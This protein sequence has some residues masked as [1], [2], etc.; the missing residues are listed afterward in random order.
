MNES[1]CPSTDLISSMASNNV[2]PV[3][4]SNPLDWDRQDVVK[5]PVPTNNVIVYD[6]NGVVVQSEV[7]RE[8]GKYVL[9][10]LAQLSP[11]GF[12]TYFIGKT[13]DS[14]N[15]IKALLT[16]DQIEN[17]FF[18]LYF[19]YNQL[20]AIFDK[21]TNTNSSLTQ[22]FLFYDPITSENGQQASGAYIFRPNGFANII[23]PTV[24][25]DF[26]AGKLVQ[27]AVQTVTPWV[28]QIIRLYQ[29]SPAIEFETQIG[30]IDISN[31]KGREIISRI[32]TDVANSNSFYTDAQGTEMTLRI[33]NHRDS[34]NVNLKEP[35]AGNYY[36]ITQAIAIN[37]SKIHYT[38][39]SDRTRGASSLNQGELE[40]MIHRR[41][42]SDDS[43]GVGEPLNEDNIIFTRDYLLRNA[44][45]KSARG[46]R[47]Q[48]QL[49]LNPIQF[50]FGKPTPLN[51]WKNQYTLTYSPLN[52]PLPPNVYIQTLRPVL[53]PMSDKRVLLRLRHIYAV[54]EDS[55]L[56]KPVTVNIANLFKN[57]SISLIKEMSL[58]GT[59]EI[60]QVKHMKW[61]TV[62][63]PITTP[64]KDTLP[65]DPPIVILS[66][67]QTRTFLLTFN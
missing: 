3:I 66:P 9:Y 19:N 59:I 6:S 10:F 32:K 67:M 41:L 61:T 20:I 4:L 7:Q 24:K 63:D 60:A 55:E 26:T 28:K 38:Y 43:R 51:T 25:A 18:K 42:V 11:L 58:L 36:P 12:R 48:M 29:N 30:P 52:A 65:N 33:L 13:R 46:Y 62:D 40:T 49:S 15:Y 57:R 17:N 2:V 31:G 50:A 53:F 35:V 27:T 34:W 44:L 5:I 1:I 14:N 16:G 47:T 37:D 39:I 45:N 8:F 64:K 21:S 54:G 22:Q 23:S 56:S